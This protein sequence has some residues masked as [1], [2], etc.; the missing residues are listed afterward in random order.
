MLL[1][2]DGGSSQT[3]RSVNFDLKYDLLSFV[4]SSEMTTYS[5]HVSPSAGIAAP[6]ARFA[7]LLCFGTN[8]L[9][10]FWIENAKVRNL[11]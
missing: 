9:D 5:V 11:I 1:A 7:R 6:A 2:P 10:T 8:A 3:D 4:V